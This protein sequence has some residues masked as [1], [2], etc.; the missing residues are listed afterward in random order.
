MSLIG[1]ISENKN[2]AYVNKVINKNFSTDTVINI[3]EKNITNIK[4]IRFETLLI[5]GNNEKIL[6]KIDILKNIIS[7]VKYLIINAD[8][9]TNLLVL[10]NIN[11]KVITFGFNSKSTITA[12]SV[13]EENI[14]ICIQRTV[15][16]V[17]KE[18]I[19]E[20]ELMVKI[21]NNKTNI[22]LLMGLVTLFIIYN[23]KDFKL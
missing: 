16:N 15:E 20:Q 10:D 17:K 2:E 13:N 1:I 12:S 14:L 11:I 3:T 23:K 7:G 5:T 18:L 22:S 9:K 8:I 6:K 21:N 19:E 4:N